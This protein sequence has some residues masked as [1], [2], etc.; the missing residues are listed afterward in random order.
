MH[1]SP[2][3]ARYRLGV[4]LALCGALATLLAGATALSSPAPVRAETKTFVVVIDAG[5][6]AKA[7]LRTEPI[8]P[9]SRKRKPRVEGGTRGVVTHRPESLDNLQVALRLRDALVARGVTV[10]MI[11]TTQKVDISNAQRARIANAAHAD[12]FI[13]LHCDGSTNHRIKGVLTLVPAR[14]KWTKGIVSASARAGRDV[15]RAVLAATHAKNRGISKRGDL[16]GFNW[17]K[18]PVALVEMGV[19][20]NPAEDRALATAAYQTKLATGLADGIMAFLEG[21]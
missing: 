5:H 19:M 16:A 21:K 8:G 14:N 20:T 12:L 4:A 2:P 1:P 10:V 17:S 18:V 15:Q 6:Q 7:D 9:G 13:R 11:R 3:P